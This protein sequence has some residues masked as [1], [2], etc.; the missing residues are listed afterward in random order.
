M[1]H[2]T[3]GRTPEAPSSSARRHR[4]SRPRSLKLQLHRGRFHHGGASRRSSEQALLVEESRSR[5]R[6]KPGVVA[7][8]VPASFAS[9]S[10]E[11]VAEM[12]NLWSNR[13]AGSKIVINERTGTIVIGKDV[14]ISPVAIMHG[15][16]TVE[17]RT[18]W[19]SRNP[20]RFRKAK[21]RY[22]ADRRDAKE[23]KAKNVVL[24]ERR[25]RSRNWCA[26]CKPSARRRATSSRSC[27]TSAAAG[28][29]NAEIEVI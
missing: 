7:V 22:A 6:R 10:V 4:S 28:A 5:A 8:D 19:K 16:L 9:R 13:I 26:R 24:R 20:S 27:K 1:N 11:F 3:V 23:E 25:H 17:V 21:P 14:Q 12:E 15:A 29:L 18:S 2:P